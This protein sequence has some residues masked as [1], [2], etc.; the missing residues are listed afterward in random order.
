MALE[1]RAAADL[2]FSGVDASGTPG[3]IQFSVPYATT[4]AAVIVAADLMMV[5]LAALTGMSLTGYSLTYSKAE[6]TPAAA[7]AKSR[8]EDKGVFIFRCT[9]GQFTRISI[10]AIVPAV[11][12]DAGQIITSD[13]AVVAFITAVTA[14][15]AIFCN[16]NGN[17]IT[18][19]DKAYQ[20]FRK[21]TGN[22]L[23][24]DKLL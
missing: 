1:N 15:G 9:Q 2:I 22:M 7:T 19:I 20:A 12:N 16:S 13:A 24:S 5:D 3:K 18:Q 11:V 14:A 21:S 6:N 23:P 8:V 17:D 4:A 10:P